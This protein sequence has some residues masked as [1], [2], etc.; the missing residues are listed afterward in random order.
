[1]A[2]GPAKDGGANPKFWEATFVL[3]EFNVVR[4]WLMQHHAEL[5]LSEHSSPRALAQILSQM[6]NFQEACLGAGA[7]GKF[8]MTR[9]PTQVFIDLSPGGGACKILASAFKHKHS[10]GL[11]RFD[12]HAPKS[13][14]RNIELLKEIEQELLS[15]DALYVRAVYI[16]DSV[17][18]QM[19]IAV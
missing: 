12:F 7:T 19:R 10:K 14:D 15:L 2:L 17:D 3:N 4:K 5:I 8:G 16:S 1:M 9:I 18:D 6:M 11:R 13:Q